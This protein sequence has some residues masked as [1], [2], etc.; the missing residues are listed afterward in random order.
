MLAAIDLVSVTTLLSAEGSVQW[1]WVAGP[2]SA[3]AICVLAWLGRE[4]AS[5]R[6]TAPRRKLRGSGGRLP[7]ARVR[8]P[9]AAG[10]VA[11][12]WRDAPAANP[13]SCRATN[14]LRKDALD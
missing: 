1:A 5:P 14:L 12:V 9:G 7:E 2:L 6:R 11:G 10:I 3:A 13:L 4:P 8:F